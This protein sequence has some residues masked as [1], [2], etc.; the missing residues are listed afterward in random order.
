MTYLFPNGTRH[1]RFR[2]L[3]LVTHRDILSVK[4]EFHSDWKGVSLDEYRS[5]RPW[6]LSLEW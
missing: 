3:T 1:S 6:S 2:T 4:V 5:G